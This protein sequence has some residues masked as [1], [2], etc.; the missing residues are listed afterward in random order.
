[1]GFAVAKAGPYWN[2]SFLL[3]EVPPVKQ[4][5]NFH[6]PTFAG[7]PLCVKYNNL[8]VG[9]FHYT[10]NW[11]CW[12]SYIGLSVL[13]TVVWSWWKLRQAPWRLKDSCFFNGYSISLVTLQKLQRCT[14]P[15]HDIKSLICAI[16][17]LY[18]STTPKI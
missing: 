12:L 7:S 4:C 16:N 2:K 13:G 14:Q 3:E 1:M 9:N 8:S 5:G 17:Y 6:I 18:H 15:F 11:L 10:S